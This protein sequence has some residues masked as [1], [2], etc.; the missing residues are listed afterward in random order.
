MQTIK[1]HFERV[2]NP[3]EIETNPKIIFFIRLPFPLIMLAI[4]RKYIVEVLNLFLKVNMK[5]DM[6]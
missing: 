6:F 4:F 2:D 5:L 3:T 1:K